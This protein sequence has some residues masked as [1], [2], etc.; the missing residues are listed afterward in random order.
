MRAEQRETITSLSLLQPRILLSWAVSAHC[1]LMSS[2]LSSRVPK[3]F[4][5]GLPSVC[6][7]VSLYTYLGL[8]FTQVQHLAPYINCA[9]QVGVISKL[10]EVHS[11]PRSRS[12][13]KMLKTTGPKT[14]PWGTPLV[15]GVHLDIEPL[16]T[17]VWLWVSNQ[18]LIHWIVYP[19]NLSFQ[20]RDKNVLWDHIKCIAEVQVDDISQS[21]F[22]YWGRQVS[23]ASNPFS[24]KKYFSRPNLRI[25][26]GIP[27]V[28]M[29]GKTYSPGMKNSQR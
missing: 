16:T 9:T 17:T 1:W 13:I 10:A 26:L 8:P 20:F 2:F 4:F 28:K 23:E 15:I 12:L 18:F 14:V 11:V 6:S 24:A 22:V 25:T 19:P 21:S 7:S 29:K 27:A 3:S 5:T